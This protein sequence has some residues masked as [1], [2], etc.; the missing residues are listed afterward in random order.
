MSP[1]S[2]DP[3]KYSVIVSNPPIALNNCLRTTRK[4]VRSRAI[5]ENS[6]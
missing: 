6:Y 1:A 4:E 3:Q 2:S 5:A